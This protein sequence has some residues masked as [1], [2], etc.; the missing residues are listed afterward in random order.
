MSPNSRESLWAVV[1]AGL[2]LAAITAAGFGL[3]AFIASAS[4]AGGQRAAGRGLDGDHQAVASGR[5]VYRQHCA[6][7][8]GTQAQGRSIFPPL[9]DVGLSREV[10]EMVVRG[11]IPPLMPAFGDRLR[12][13]QT[14]AVAEYIASLNPGARPGAA[15]GQ[16]VAQGRQPDGGQSVTGPRSGGDQQ[17][18]MRGRLVFRLNCA[19]CHGLQ[20]EGRGVAPPLVNVGLSRE[21]VEAAVRGGIPPLMPAFG[22]RLRSDQI[23]AVAEYVASLNRGASPDGFPGGAVVQGVARP[24]GRGRGFSGGMMCPMM[25]RRN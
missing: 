22:N 9:A 15:P 13:D 17:D 16:T 7:C 11:G 23:Q 12:S 25:G 4:S 14:Q 18:T 6:R 5:L 19:S 2:A 8:H 10:V 24:P 1:V 21:E 3:S 20:A